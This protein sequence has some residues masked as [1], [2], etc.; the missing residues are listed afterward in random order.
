MTKSEEDEGLTNKW[1]Q[2][3]KGYQG[4]S[5]SSIEAYA[6][7]QQLSR[8]SLYKW[9]KRL[10]MPLRKE[11]LSFIE[12][13]PTAELASLPLESFSVEVRIN[14]RSTVA[15]AAPWPKVIELVKALV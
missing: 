5:F 12:L 8:S 9:S 1:R 10:G 11:T 13:E 4:S 2:I 15:M 6:D 14:N 7:S 3:I